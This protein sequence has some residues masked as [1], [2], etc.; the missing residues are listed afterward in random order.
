MTFEFYSYSFDNFDPFTLT[1]W[2]SDINMWNSQWYWPLGVSMKIEDI[3]DAYSKRS[4]YF[5]ILVFFF[6]MYLAVPGLNCSKH[7]LVS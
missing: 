4:M 3:A 5:N 2:D 1:L 7:D 6:L